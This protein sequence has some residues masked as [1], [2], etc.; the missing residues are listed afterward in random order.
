MAEVAKSQ[1]TEIIEGI[2]SEVIAGQIATGPHSVQCI[3]VEVSS[4]STSA[5]D[6][7]LTNPKLSAH[8]KPTLAQLARELRGTRGAADMLRS[9]GT[10]S[11]D[12]RSSGELATGELTFARHFYAH[13]ATV[14]TDADE[15]PPFRL[16]AWGFT[17]QAPSTPFSPLALRV[18]LDRLHAAIR[19]RFDK[20]STDTFALAMRGGA[21]RE[22][23]AVLAALHSL[24]ALA[25]WQYDE[26]A[27]RIRTVNTYGMG[28]NTMSVPVGPSEGASR[29]GIVSQLTPQRTPVIYDA[30]DPALWRPS[31]AG[32]WEPFDVG[33][34]ADRGWRSCLAVPIVC[35]GRLIGALSAYSRRSA[36]L[37][38]PL[39]G[40]LASAAATCGDVILLHREDSVIA[41]LAARYDEELL[42]ANVSLSA[43]SL[44][45]DVMHYY[46]SVQI[47]VA[48]TQAYLTTNQL[49]EAQRTL[50]DIEQTMTRTGPA[51]KAMRKLA[52]EA[53]SSQSSREPQVTRDV[54]SVMA[55]LEGLLRAILPHF[56][57]SRNLDPEK[58]T[59]EV[60]G[61]P[62][63]VSVPAMTLERIVVNLCVNSAQ[64]NATRILVTG[65]FERSDD[66]FQLVV[67]DDGRGIPR[68]ARDRVFD[69]FYSGRK[70]SGLGLYVVKSLASRAGG[71][72]Y[73]Q[74]Y[75]YSDADEQHGTVM[76]V[77]LPIEA[78]AGRAT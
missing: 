31:G 68:P 34:F 38:D 71:E 49:V 13:Q 23:L 14:K 28:E 33:L 55:E 42:T 45:H 32:S 73:L 74:S 35:R 51:I 76:T 41:S 78:P 16:R 60:K 4:G 64:W 25:L 29:R 3:G 21:V 62:K 18:T 20:P 66:E 17:S 72:V 69:R 30:Q 61:T 24:D 27:R 1:L 26:I 39:S 48:E 12:L 56:A 9:T 2:L 67:R 47:R 77:V 59:V 58:I 11:L 40:K 10:L 44:I 57:R 15:L 43:L 52:T 63:P 65:H 53:R 75:D 70:G 6:I 5:A 7:G 19:A 46:R 50:Q 37:L 22:G 36:A 54:P 8:E